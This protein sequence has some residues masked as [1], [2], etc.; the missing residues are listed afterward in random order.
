MMAMAHARNRMAVNDRRLSLKQGSFEKLPVDDASM[1]GI[2]A[3]NVL[4]FVEPLTSALAEA[5][6]VLRLA[7]RWSSTSRTSPSCRGFNSTGATPDRHSISG[8]FA[9]CSAQALSGRVRSK[10]AACG[11]HSGFA[12][13]WQRSP[14]RSVCHI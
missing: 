6:R 12:E 3:V 1:D 4:Y 11:F 2:L 8:A 14:S 7:D 10:F 5:W 13:F 9:D